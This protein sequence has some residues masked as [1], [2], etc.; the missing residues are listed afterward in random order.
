MEQVTSADL[1]I[2]KGAEELQKVSLAPAEKRALFNSLSEYTEAHP[3][4]TTG[5]FYASLVRVWR[6]LFGFSSWRK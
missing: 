3:A 4:P 6:G 1:L 5:E 2:E